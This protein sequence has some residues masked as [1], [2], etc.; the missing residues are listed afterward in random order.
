MG[1]PAQIP[2]EEIYNKIKEA[3]QD[4]PQRDK[5][6]NEDYAKRICKYA[7]V[8]VISGKNMSRVKRSN[9]YEE[10]KELLYAEA[11]YRKPTASTNDAEQ[12][13]IDAEQLY[14]PCIGS[15]SAA[16]A[17]MPMDINVILSKILDAVSTENPVKGS[18]IDRLSMNICGSLKKIKVELEEQ[19]VMIDAHFCNIA[20]ELADIKSRLISQKDND[21][22]KTIYDTFGK[23]NIKEA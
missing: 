13:T 14:A 22:L 23:D 21:Y 3:T 2:S 9:S 5:E 6:S 7:Q 20:E 4:I 18:S 1:R 10:Y 19:R 11:H 12:V 17:V 15:V 8:H 16:P